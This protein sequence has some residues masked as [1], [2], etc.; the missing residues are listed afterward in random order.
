MAKVRLHPLFKYLRGSL[1]GMVFRLSHNGKTSAYMS[2][3][4]SRV[5][6]SQDQ[7][8]HRERMAEAFTYASQ[9]TKDPEIREVYVQMALKQKKNE[10]RPYDMAVSDY[11]HTRN[12][13][14]GNRFYW[15]ADL[16]RANYEDR[17]RK[18]MRKK[19]W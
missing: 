18:R 3:N 8:A 4:M 16:W 14:L 12:N 17:K 15:S 13:L 9:A 2:P 19:H 5:E 10:N 7:D 1:K 11:Y 6:W